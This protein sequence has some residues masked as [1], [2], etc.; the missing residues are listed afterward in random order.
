MFLGAE[1]SEVKKLE[2]ADLTKM[3]EEDLLALITAH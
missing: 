2:E 3:T 1:D